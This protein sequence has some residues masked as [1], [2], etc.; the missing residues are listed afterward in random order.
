M[1]ARRVLI[2]ERL[3]LLAGLIAMVAAVVSLD[4]RIGLFFAG[5]LACASA[6]DVSW[7]RP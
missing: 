7:R 6:L 4:W 2:T 3:I 1:N 5:L